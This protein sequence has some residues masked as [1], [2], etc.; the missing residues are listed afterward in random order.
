M[1][2]DMN[3]LVKFLNNQLLIILFVLGVACCFYFVKDIR[4]DISPGSIGAVI[5]IFFC[6][7]SARGAKSWDEKLLVILGLAVTFISQIVS[8]HFS[9]C[10]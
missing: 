9:T 1:N 6:V 10:S 5:G 8:L 3:Q 7:L 2:D 4:T